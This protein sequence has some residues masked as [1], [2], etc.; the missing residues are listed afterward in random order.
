MHVL[1]K[2]EL[3][4]QLVTARNENKILRHESDGKDLAIHSCEKTISKQDE[5]IGSLKHKLEQAEFELGCVKGQ[6]YSLFER[7]SGCEVSEFSSEQVKYL[8]D[9]IEGQMDADS[10]TIEKL[11]QENLI[12][13]YE[14]NNDIAMTLG[15]ITEAQQLISN[16]DKE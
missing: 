11:K 9:M 12:L 5:L 7:V 3:R 10:G 2:E 13:R 16:R 1:T 14:S 8:S 15:E 6:L 4:E